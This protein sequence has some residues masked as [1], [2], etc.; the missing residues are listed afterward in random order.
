MMPKGQKEEDMT[1]VKRSFVEGIPKAEL[2]V[3]LEGTL[4]PDLKLKLAQKNGID[5]GMSTV[6]EIKETYQFT[7]LTSFLAVY[8]PG[9]QVLVEEDDFYQLAMAYFRKAKSQGVRYA[10]VFFDPQAHTS[11]GVSFD[12]VIRGY[13]R[14][15]KE[16]PSLGIEA[17]LVM[18]FLRDMSLE[19][20]LDH[21]EMARPYRDWIVGVGLDSDERN[22]PPLKFEKVFKKA[23]A[24]GY[25]ITVHCDIDQEDSVQHIRDVLYTIGASRID[26]GTN[27]VEDP[28]LVDYAVKHKI[29]FTNCPVSNSFVTEDMKGKEIKYLL[30]KGAKVTINSDDPAYFQSYIADDMLAL[31][32]EVDLSQ[33]ELVR[34]VKN[35]FEVAWLPPETK[36]AYLREVDQYLQKERV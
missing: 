29:G 30:D 21:Y 12:A 9:M 22:N 31:A 16:A 13:Q 23:K 11:R 10:E 26:H 5:L 18:C 34:L 27:I 36:E 33:E 28:E 25:E 8:Y 4:E 17:Q 32:K 24:D 1:Q 14:A 7:D 3:H 15:I 19:S 35:A 2:H 6:E 20:A